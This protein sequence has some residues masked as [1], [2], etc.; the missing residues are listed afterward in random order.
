ME[1]LQYILGYVVSV[2]MVGFGLLMVSGFI[3]PRFAVGDPIRVTFG[4]VVLLYGVL[5]FVQTRMKAK[6]RGE[7]A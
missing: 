1:N 6:R 2:L 5:R 7:D 4:V 3:A